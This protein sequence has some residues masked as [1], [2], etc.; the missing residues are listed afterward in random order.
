MVRDGD[1]FTVRALSLDPTFVP[2]LILIR[3]GEPDVQVLCDAF[4]RGFPHAGF[5]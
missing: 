2:A 4:R 5:R 3:G 1:E